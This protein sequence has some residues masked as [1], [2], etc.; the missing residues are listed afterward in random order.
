MSAPLVGLGLLVALVGVSVVAGRQGV[1]PRVAA[2]AYAVSLLGWGLIPVVWLAC[3]GGSLGSALAGARTSDGGCPLGLDHL[4]W[5]L[6]GF[7]PAAVV[8]GVLVARWSRGAVA[9]RRAEMRGGTL[10][11]AVRRPTRNGEVWVIPSSKP[12]AFA[13]GLW[14]PRAV[15]SSGLLA[16]LGKHE[17]RAVCEHEAAHV[18]LGHSRL[19]LLCGAVAASYGRLGPVRQAWGG[20]RR[21]LEAAADDEAASVVGSEVLVSALMQVALMASVSPRAT[22]ASFGDPEHLRYRLARLGNGDTVATG[23]TV[24]AGLSA[25]VASS[26][27][28]A[29]ACLLAGAPATLLG[30]AACLGPIA[31]FGLRPTWAWRRTRRR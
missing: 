10:D 13:A 27:M 14:R 8:L 26:A 24:A 28:A 30:V 29:V 23:P 19:L 5:Q 6:L 20:L 2:G 9:A 22:A 12:V 3:L 15:V 31:V 16:P 1:S 18:R 25:A 21:E 7:V 11:S 4:Q 17:R